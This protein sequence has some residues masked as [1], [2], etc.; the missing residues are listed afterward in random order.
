MGPRPT[1][2]EVLWEPSEQQRRATNLA[3]YMDWLANT[4][5]LRFRDYQELWRWSVTDLEAFWASIWDYFRVG[6]PGAYRRVLADPRMPGARWFQGAELNYAA[7]ALSRRDDHPALLFR[8]EALGLDRLQTITYA[9]LAEQVGA[10]RAGLQ[11][12]GVSRGDRVVA[13]LPN[14]PEAVIGFLA[15]AS[16]GATW[17][18]CSPDFGT[19]AVVDRFRQIEPKVLLAVSGYRYN[20]RD[21]DR[22]RELADIRH[23]LPTLA[24][25]VAVDS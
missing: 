19:R 2:G 13:Y 25:T 14:I 18:S 4:R 6:P 3:R 15:A 22:T 24:A 8:S 5:G 16:L 21:I 17:S 1:E 10:V 11:R 12:L 7:Q 20:G 23:S 9:Q